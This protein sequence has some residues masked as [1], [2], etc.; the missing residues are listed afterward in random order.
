MSIEFDTEHP[1]ILVASCASRMGTTARVSGFLAA[2]RLYIIELHQFDD[3]LSQRFFLRATFCGVHGEGVDLERLR[4][5]F[6]TVAGIE[7]MEWAIHDT[8]A[9]GGTTSAS[10]P[11]VTPARLCIRFRKAIRPSWSI[12]AYRS[13]RSRT[14]FRAPRLT[15]RLLESSSPHQ[16]LSRDDR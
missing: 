2:H 10:R 6:S 1:Y 13:M 9:S 12:A 11:W 4:R 3:T 15:V 16:P 7:Q 14:C 8:R 5:E